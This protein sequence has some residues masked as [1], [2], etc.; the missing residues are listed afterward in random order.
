M[1]KSLE[2]WQAHP[3]IDSH[4]KFPSDRRLPDEMTYG[5]WK[6]VV[7]ERLH[8]NIHID[9]IILPNGQGPTDDMTLGEIRAS[10]KNIT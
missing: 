2:E 8:P 3:S 9:G 7:H 5:N 10:L 6:A 4:F 1:T